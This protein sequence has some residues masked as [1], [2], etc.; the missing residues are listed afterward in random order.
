MV[1]MYGMKFMDFDLDSDFFRTNEFEWM[2]GMLYINIGFRF[3][4]WMGSCGFYFLVILFCVWY[5]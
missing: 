3:E 5:N 2:V 1:E 4:F